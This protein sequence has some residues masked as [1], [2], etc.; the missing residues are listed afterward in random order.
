MRVGVTGASGFCG[1]ASARML[2]T[3]GHEVVTLGRSGRV[4]PG[5]EHRTWDAALPEAPD[6]GGLDAVVHVAAAVGDPVGRAAE[7]A[8]RAVNVDGTR[9]LLDAAAGLRVV[10]VS[11]ASVYD[12]RLDRSCVSEDHPTD[13]GH[14]NAYG[15]TKA[16]ADALALA[17]G[18]VVLRPR[19]VHGPGDPHLLPRLRQIV[20]GGR[21]LLPGPSVPLSLTHVDTLAEACVRGLDWSPGPYNVADRTPYDRDTVVR[22]VLTAALGSPVVVRHVPARAATAAAVTAALVGRVLGRE[23]RLTRYAVDQ[24]ARPCVLDLTR[25]R[26]T[27]WDP[28]QRPPAGSGTLPP[29][30]TSSWNACSEPSSRSRAAGSSPTATSR[31][32]SASDPGT[33]AR[34]S[35]PTAGTSRGGG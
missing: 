16:A 24:L 35:R 30:T 32:S 27:G 10:V 9:R 33:S 21:V 14:P 6:L 12:G 31:P 17:A 13:G 28:P 7:E 3:A 8:F 18:A 15:R 4:R 22:E 2:A 25:L 34:S 1:G 23:P 5:W 29:W 26:A 11:S 20:R 19:A